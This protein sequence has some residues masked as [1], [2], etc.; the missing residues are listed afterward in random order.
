MEELIS[1]LLSA[2]PGGPSGRLWG[3]KAEREVSLEKH[4]LAVSI[5]GQVPVVLKDLSMKQNSLSSTQSVAQYSDV[6]TL[7]LLSSAEEWELL[8][9]FLRLKNP[10][11]LGIR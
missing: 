1:N 7:V 8:Y 11:F 5:E 4:C 10:A 9:H 3:G 2:F 6:R